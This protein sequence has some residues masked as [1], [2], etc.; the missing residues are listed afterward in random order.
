V[1]ENTHTFLAEAKLP[2]GCRS[3]PGMF[4]RVRLPVKTVK[5]TPAVPS[6]AVLT[7]PSG[8]PIAFVLDDGKTVKRNIRTGLESKGFIQILDGVT[9]GEQVI[10]AG[11]ERLKDGMPVKVRPGKAYSGKPGKKPKRPIK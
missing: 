3:I 4:A 11:N 6:S 9:A 8:R 2:M 7:S 5:N 1:D 10:V